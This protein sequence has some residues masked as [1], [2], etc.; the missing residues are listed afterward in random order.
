MK[1]ISENELGETAINTYLEGCKA[2]YNPCDMVSQHLSGRANL[3]Q[4]L[5]AKLP[6]I[7]VSW[8]FGGAFLAEI[9]LNAQSFADCYN[10]ALADYRQK[11]NVRSPNHPLPDLRQS[12]EQIETPLW[13]YQPAGIRRPLWIETQ[14]DQLIIFAGSEKVGRLSAEKLLENPQEALEQLA[15]W[16]VRPRALTLTLWARL[17]IC[18]FLVHGIGGAKYDRITDRIIERYFDCQ[19]PI[20]G[21]VTA[22]LRLPLKQFPVGR[23]DFLLARHK[24][25]DIRY[26]PDR[27]VINPP[28][29][30]LEKRHNLITQSNNLRKNR[31]SK[32]ERQQIFKEIREINRRIWETD[33]QTVKRVKKEYAQIATELASNHV[34]NQREFF[35]ALQP[36]HR[37]VKLAD[38]LKEKYNL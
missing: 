7:R 14:A 21:C 25:R 11:E 2:K 28:A 26:N 31:G 17:L 32:G 15:P 12:Q 38:R 5:S 1:L 19:P 4:E 29:D 22:T 3:D 8:A 20:Y 37:L 16:V 36:R 9:L 13:I 33:P 18:D 27:Y 30:M 10:Q 24:Q 35:Y 23:E 34:A 6:D